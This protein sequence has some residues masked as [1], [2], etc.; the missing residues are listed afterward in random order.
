MGDYLLGIPFSASRYVPPGWY[1]QRLRNNWAYFTDDWKVSS[2]LTVNLG[3][4]YE[5][6]LPTTEKRGQFGSFLPSARGGRGA[7]LVPNEKSVSPPYLQSSVERSWP[8]YSQ[9]S[10]YAKDVGI[11]E[12]YLR[13]TGHYGWAPRIGLAYRTR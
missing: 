2:K 4:R 1:Y 5:L 9:F 12:K 13:A 3:I 6:N 10:V 7:I 11:S 8:F